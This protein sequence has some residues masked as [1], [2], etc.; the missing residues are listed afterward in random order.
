VKA[1]L[2][3]ILARLP[4]R[5]LWPLAALFLSAIAFF[6][7]LKIGSEM[8]EG[9]TRAFDKALIYALRV[10]GHPNR[11]IGP[12]WLELAAQDITSL[13]S[14]VVLAFVTLAVAGYL[15]LIVRRQDA[16]LLL[17][18]VPGGLGFSSALKAFYD[19]PRPD[20]V[21]EAVAHLNASFP[22]GHAM[23]SAVTYLTLAAILARAQSGRNVKAYLYGLALLTTAM[24]GVSRVYLGL[25]WPSDVLAGWCVGAGWAILCRLVADYA[26]RL[27]TPR[28]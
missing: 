19:R 15:A 6:I 11:P 23:L 26:L 1:R 9:E 3:A 7:F 8:M 28:N 24:V 2:K 14:V 22:S 20:L 16:L 21:P 4:E 5:D 10:P 27:K 25:H 18:A 13:G 17:A 12:A